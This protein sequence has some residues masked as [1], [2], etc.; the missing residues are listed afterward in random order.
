MTFLSLMDN[1]LKDFSQIDLDCTKLDYLSLCMNQIESINLTNCDNFKFLK[2]KFK[3][4][5]N[6][7][8]YNSS[9]SLKNVTISNKILTESEK[10]E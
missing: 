5:Y 3:I 9:E 10:K 7:H 1:R 6:C 8:S 4:G 2:T